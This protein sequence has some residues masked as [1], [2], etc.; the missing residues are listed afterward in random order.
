MVTDPE[1]STLQLTKPA[2]G[3]DPETVQSTSHPH[4]SFLVF[5]MDISQQRSPPKRYILNDT[6]TFK[7]KNF[8]DL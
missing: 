1:A 2:T 7:V 5:Q 4:I 8:G 6:S 3:H